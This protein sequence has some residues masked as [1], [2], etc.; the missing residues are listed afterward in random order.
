MKLEMRVER[1]ELKEQSLGAEHCLAIHNKPFFSM[2][3]MML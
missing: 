2:G 1:F 3:A